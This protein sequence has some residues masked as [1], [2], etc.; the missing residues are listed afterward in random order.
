MEISLI[1][2]FSLSPILQPLQDKGRHS[3]KGDDHPSIWRLKRY[4]RECG[5]RKNYK[6]LLAGC[7]SN[8]AQVRVLKEELES[9]GVEGKGV[10]V[11]SG[12]N[13]QVGGGNHFQRR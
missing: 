2:L 6:K 5:V 11:E 9:L 1:L 7:R 3:G 4:I 10:L 8:K 13:W 12:E